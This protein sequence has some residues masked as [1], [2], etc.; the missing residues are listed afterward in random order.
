MVAYDKLVQQGRIAQQGGA[1]ETYEELVQEGKRAI[2]KESDAKWT[3]GDLALKVEK[4][5]GESKLQQFAIDIGID[6]STLR[7]RV[8]ASRAWPGNVRR[9]TV[10]WSVHYE[11]A[12]Q[13]DRFDLISKVG[14]VRDVR[15]R[16]GNALPPN[17]ALAG[18]PIEERVAAVRSA[19]DDPE[20]AREVIRDDKTSAKVTQAQIRVQRDIK[21][22]AAERERTE[23]PGAHHLDKY[24]YALARLSEARHALTRALNAAQA[25][26][27]GDAE[28]EQFNDELA[29][30]KAVID[31]WESYLTSGAKATDEAIAAL[32]DGTV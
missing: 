17:R 28:V 31:W 19:L 22:Y 9:R 32:L 8:A 1:M 2:A 21:E 18:L 14:S 13:D 23:Q 27:V 7:N 30:I 24:G 3:V 10:S 26:T 16:L 29:A 6:Y 20:V 25:I 5:Y 12:G 11:L 4:R 15:R